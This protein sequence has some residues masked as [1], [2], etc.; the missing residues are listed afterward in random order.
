MTQENV[1]QSLLA[2]QPYTPLVLVVDDD[3][4]QHKLFSKLGEELGFRPHAVFSCEQAVK[5]V[6]SCPFD[7]ILLDWSMPG[8]DGATCAKQIRAL[9]QQRGTHTPIVAVT[10][11]AF[12]DIEKQCYESG[13]DDFLTKPFTVEELRA[14]MRRWIS[15]ENATNWQVI[16]TDRFGKKR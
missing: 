3:R 10:G 12:A 2:N 6:S 1:F 15:A 7:L 5:A 13:M 8:A 14:K 11:H 4:I 16:Q 9:E